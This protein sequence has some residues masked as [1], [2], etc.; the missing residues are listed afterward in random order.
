M[1]E[2]KGKLIHCNGIIKCQEPKE[3]G[4]KEENGLDYDSF[5]NIFF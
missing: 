3:E 1:E 4:Y 2:P 5:R